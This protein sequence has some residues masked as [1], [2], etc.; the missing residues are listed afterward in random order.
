M[1]CKCK[2]KNKVAKSDKT[3]LAKIYKI[4]NAMKKRNGMSEA[5]KERC[6]LGIAKRWG[7][8]KKSIKINIANSGD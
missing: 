8:K 5:K 3:K 2:K 4:C 7:V 6:V 1:V